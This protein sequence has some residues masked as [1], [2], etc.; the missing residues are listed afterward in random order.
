MAAR[1]ALFGWRLGHRR[2]LLQRE[3]W[4]PLPTFGPGI[5]RSL[6]SGRERPRPQETASVGHQPSTS[7]GASS[8]SVEEL[9]RLSRRLQKVH[10]NVLAK[11]LRKSVTTHGQDLL[12]VDKPFG[13]PMS[14]AP[15]EGP[16]IEEVLPV[17][18]KMMFGM[19]A[20][21]LHLCHRLDKDSSGAMLLARDLYTAQAVQHLFRQHRVI[22]KYWVITVGVPV[23]PEGV[24]DIP[25]IEREVSSPRKHFKMALAPL[26][27]VGDVEG[28]MLRVRQSRAAHSAVTQYR[29]MESCGSAALL[30]VQPLTGVKHQLRVHLALA[31]SCPILGDHKYS[32]WNSL[33]PQ[34][35]PEGML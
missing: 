24:I 5:R 8:Q 10:P 32:K 22:K 17:L 4:G 15:G 2:G 11:V 18:A 20:P 3:G 29:V 21:P 26:F 30:E 34:K 6:Q 16:S 25:I 1:A 27:R 13:V 23:P 35:L 12:A 9:R 31:L 7:S 28:T 19:K 14:A 33:Q